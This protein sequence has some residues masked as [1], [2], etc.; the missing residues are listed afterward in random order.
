MAPDL[1]RWGGDQISDSADYND[2]IFEDELI[3]VSES[4][5]VRSRATFKDKFTSNIVAD[6]SYVCDF[7]II[8]LHLQVSAINNYQ[9]KS[10]YFTLSRNCHWPLV[11]GD[12]GIFCLFL[13][14]ISREV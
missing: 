10:C 13:P 4:D 5:D 12:F 7:K 11:L 1:L 6:K 14:R 8:P 9:E 2:E 3:R